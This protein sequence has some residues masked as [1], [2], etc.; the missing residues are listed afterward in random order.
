MKSIVLSVAIFV[1]FISYSNA[2]GFSAGIK[3]G[4]NVNKLTGKSFNEQFTYG[5]HAGAFAQIKISKRLELQPEVVFNQVNTDTSSQFSQL[6]K[7]NSSKIS[8][9]KLTYLSIPLI[10]NYKLSK[11]FSI[12]AGPQYGILL[13]QHKDLLQNG[14]SAFKDGDFSLLAGIQIKFASFRVYGRYVV[15]LNNINDIDNQDKWKN[16]S[17]QLGVGFAIF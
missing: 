10:L 16:Q 4:A 12:Q 9:I 2:Q 8:N 5:Y 11:G 7:I 17:L 6:Y 15:G 14:K 3:A 1:S 13:D